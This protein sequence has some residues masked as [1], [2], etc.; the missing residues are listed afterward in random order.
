MDS[1]VHFGKTSAGAELPFRRFWSGSRS[2]PH[3]NKF[4]KIYPQL[5]PDDFLAVYAEAE[6]LAALSKT[7][8]G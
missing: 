2:E 7:S 5:E 8:I 4:W 6:E 3:S 1:R